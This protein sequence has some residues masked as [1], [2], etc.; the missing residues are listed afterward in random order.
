MHESTIKLVFKIND[1][2]IYTNKQ[3]TQLSFVVDLCHDI[4]LILSVKVLQTNYSETFAKV[5]G[6]L[7]LSLLT[8]TSHSLLTI[9]QNLLK[10]VW[11][12]AVVSTLT[13][14]ISNMNIDFANKL[15]TCPSLVSNI[16]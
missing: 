6:L 14:I 11:Y 16:R 7:F 15:K 9:S 1:C 2:K 10:Q 5:N 8:F 12:I 13:K 4:K 3:E